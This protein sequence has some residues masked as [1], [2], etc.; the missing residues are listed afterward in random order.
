MNIYIYIYIYLKLFGRGSNVL[1]LV[2][3]N[4]EYTCNN[5]NIHPINK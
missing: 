2:Y 5:V 4:N 1:K 3:Y